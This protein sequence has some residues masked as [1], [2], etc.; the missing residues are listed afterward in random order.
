MNTGSKL[1]AAAG[2]RAGQLGGRSGGGPTPGTNRRR[3]PDRVLLGPRLPADGV[4][5]GRACDRG[6][7]RHRV[8]DLEV[9]ARQS[10]VPERRVRRGCTATLSPESDA[11]PLSSN[12]WRSPAR[13]R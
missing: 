13:S 4:A 2:C 8:G 5:P 6:G 10:A 12:E 7:H 9:D 3:R 1:I 11:S